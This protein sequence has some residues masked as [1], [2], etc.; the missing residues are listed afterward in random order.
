MSYLDVLSRA[1]Q[2]PATDY[3]L[4]LLHKPQSSDTVHH[5]F[6]NE[7]VAKIWSDITQ[8]ETTLYKVERQKHSSLYTDAGYPTANAF[9]ISTNDLEWKDANQAWLE[10]QNQYL[11]MKQKCSLFHSGEAEPL[12][13]PI[14]DSRPQTVEASSNV[15]VQE[16]LDVGFTS[17]N[18]LLSIAGTFSSGIEDTS[19]NVKTVITDILLKKYGT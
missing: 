18:F 10:S 7:G 6:I 4:C 14:R 5:F 2:G 1:S 12:E 11:N 13:L 8:L 3:H 16:Q 17:K 19:E 15:N 9:N